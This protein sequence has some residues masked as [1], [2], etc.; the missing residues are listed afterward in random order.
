MTDVERI[1]ILKQDGLLLFTF[2]YL[3][4][5]GILKNSTGEIFKNVNIFLCSYLKLHHDDKWWSMTGGV[6]EASNS[7]VECYWVLRCILHPKN[8]NKIK[9]IKIKQNCYLGSTRYT[10]ILPIK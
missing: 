8:N 7:C 3:F 5:R 2:M 10:K 4:F 6:S 1:S 9:K